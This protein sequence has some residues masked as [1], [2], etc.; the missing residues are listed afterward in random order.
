MGVG[1]AMLQLFCS[2]LGEV[3]IVTMVHYT[4]FNRCLVEIVFTVKC[5]ILMLDW[6]VALL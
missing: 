2:N 5:L 6:I 4:C 3:E 1:E